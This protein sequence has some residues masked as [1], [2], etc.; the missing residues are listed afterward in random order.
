L[1]AVYLFIPG[2]GKEGYRLPR[3]NNP[4]GLAIGMGFLT[5]WL[6]A[7]I[8]P[9]MAG[10][11]LQS[12]K[13]R[14]LV[15][16]GAVAGGLSLLIMLPFY[17]ADPVALWYTYKFQGN[18]KLAGE[19][20]WFLVQYH[21]LDPQKTLP[22]RPWNEPELILLSNGLLTAIQL[23]LV[24]GV[25]GLAAWRLWQVRRQFA[26]LCDR[27][28]AAGLIGVVIFTLA[29]RVYSP[30][31]MILIAWALSAVLVLSSVG[32]RGNI[33]FCS[34]LTLAGVANFLVFHLGAFEE[35]WLRFS[36]I[37]FVAIWVLTIWLLWKVLSLPR[38]PSL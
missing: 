20:M 12:K 3:R 38:Q 26:L 27:W 19:S 18:R 21:W 8:T 5:K 1:A 32:W 10:A 34:L 28:A 22:S 14:E 11:Y 15:I 24:A 23:G 35:E 16:M 4:A 37:F 9:F 2:R 13:W 30:Q 6:P 31:F 17:L 33:L 36:L 29:N 25:L 7:V